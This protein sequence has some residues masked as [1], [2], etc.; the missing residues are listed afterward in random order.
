MGLLGFAVGHLLSLDLPSA[1]CYRLAPCRLS[2]HAR[3]PA[4][5]MFTCHAAAARLPME[6]IALDRLA[7]QPIWRLRQQILATRVR[8]RLL[9]ERRQL[10][11]LHAIAPTCHGGGATAVSF[12]SRTR[13]CRGGSGA[14]GLLRVHDGCG[15]GCM[16]DRIRLEGSFTLLP[17]QEGLAWPNVVVKAK[18]TDPTP[19][20]S[21]P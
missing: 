16:M 9:D 3:R 18:A 15:C 12:L 11:A 2:Q 14:N 4:P 6:D 1:I 17:P 19:G 7:H 8:A 21:T 20:S 5:P 10:A 13:S